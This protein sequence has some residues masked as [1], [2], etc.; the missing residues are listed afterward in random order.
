MTSKHGQLDIHLIDWIDEGGNQIITRSVGTT[1]GQGL[2]EFYSTKHS[3]ILRVQFRNENIILWNWI[4]RFMD[5]AKE[6]HIEFQVKPLGNYSDGNLV[7]SLL[8]HKLG[9]TVGQYESH[10]AFTLP[11]LNRIVNGIDVYDPKFSIIS[12]G[13][14]VSV[15]FLYT[16][17]EKRLTEFHSDIEG[18]L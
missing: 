18:L 14:D 1:C 11:G 17:E 16:E 12:V 5:V 9:H 3:S 2:E 8:S 15:Y 13:A 10:T 4:S 6:L 7:V